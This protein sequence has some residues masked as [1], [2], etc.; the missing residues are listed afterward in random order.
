MIT[1]YSVP[2]QKGHK[3]VAEWKR[4]AGIEDGTGD[5]FVPAV[6]A[7]NEMIVFLCAGYDAEPAAYLDKHLFVR[8]SWMA[9][10][11]PGLRDICEKIEANVRGW[12]PARPE[13][14]G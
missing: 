3:R 11:F 6:I 10:E 7:G 14:P 1:W 5:V 8:A 13:E 4:S 9:K 12:T 2:N